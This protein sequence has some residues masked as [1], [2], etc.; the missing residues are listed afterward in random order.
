[1][2]PSVFAKLIY[3]LVIDHLFKGAEK[4][5]QKKQKT[6]S[7]RCHNLSFKNQYHI[8]I[9]LGEKKSASNISCGS[10][11]LVKTA[12]QERNR[13]QKVSRRRKTALV[14]I[15]SINIIT[16]DFHHPLIRLRLL[17]RLNIMFN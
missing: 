3:S 14:A 5:K 15:P 10:S 8:F 17:S 11:C 2:S 4:E 13:Q 9:V 6:E 16:S 1:M 7:Q 12:K